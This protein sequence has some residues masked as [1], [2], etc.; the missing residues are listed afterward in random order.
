MKK[1]IGRPSASVTACSLVF[2]PPFVRPIRRP[3]CSPGPPFSTEG[4]SPCGAL[5]G[6][7]L[8][9][10]LVSAAAR[11][12]ALWPTEQAMSVAKEIAAAEGCNRPN[13]TGW[14]YSEPSLVWHGGRGTRPFPATATAS[15]GA[16]PKACQVILRAR[17]SPTAPIPVIRGC[18][19]ARTLTGFAIGAGQWIT[20]DVLDCSGDP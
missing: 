14:G 2:M 6:A 16:H 7:F 17:L 13:V 1:R 19:P 5:A 20:L 3:L 11:V 8:H 10:G 18:R 9:A 12:P 4:W 15:E